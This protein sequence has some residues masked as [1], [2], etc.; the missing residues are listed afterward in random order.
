MTNPAVSTHFDQPT[1]VDSQRDS[2]P[3]E[4]S[5]LVQQKLAS[6]LGDL[7]SEAGAWRD[8]LAGLAPAAQSATDDW[9]R[10]ELPVAESS[11]PVVARGELEVR[12][13]LKATVSTATSS[14]AW[15]RSAQ[16]AQRWGGIKSVSRQTC[17]SL[18]VRLLVRCGPEELPAV[19]SQFRA[20]AHDGANVRVLLSE[21][22]NLEFLVVDGRIGY[23]GRVDDGEVVLYEVREPIMVWLLA[24]MFSL[25]WRMSL[26]MQDLG[27][28]SLVLGAEV[29][30]DIVRLLIGGAKDETIA[31]TVGLSLRT[32]RRHVAEIMAAV[33]ADSRFQAGFVLARGTATYEAGRPG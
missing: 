8:R 1:A 2:E 3:E 26:P 25:V 6:L 15:S 28:L 33:A 32:C 9:Q 5:H 22:A 14:L 21:Q 10:P 23:L 4:T 12:S 20:S 18:D 30:R 27:A 31:R 13:R 19:T 17:E 29:K 7:A 11:F 24:D 16:D